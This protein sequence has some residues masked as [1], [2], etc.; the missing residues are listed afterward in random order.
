MAHNTGQFLH[1][2]ERSEAR[3]DGGY[4][5]KWSF[6]VCAA[7]EDED[8]DYSSGMTTQKTDKQAST[9]S[10]G[11]K[12][13]SLRHFTTADP[14][15]TYEKRSSNLVRHTRL[16]L[17]PPSATASNYLTISPAPT[18]GLVLQGR[19]FQHAQMTSAFRKPVQRNDSSSG[20]DAQQGAEVDNIMLTCCG[21]PDDDG[22][23]IKRLVH[24]KRKAAETAAVYQTVCAK[25]S[26]PCEDG[27]ECHHCGN[28]PA[29]LS[30]PSP[31]APLRSQPC[32][33]QSFY[34]ASPAAGG[35]GRPPRA[36][37]LP[38][39]LAGINGRSPPL[40]SA[41]CC[42]GA[43]KSPRGRRKTA[44][45]QHHL[46]HP[47]VLSSDDDAAAADDDD[48][49]AGS[50]SR[51]DSVSPQ[52]ADSAHSSPAPCGGRVEAAVKSS[53]EREE[54]GTDFFDDVNMKMFIPRRT[55]MKDQFGKQLRS[56]RSKRSK[57]ESGKCGSIILQCRS[58][59][60]GT[61]RRMVTKPVVFSVEHIQ[62]ETEGPELNMVEKV[63]LRASELIS[64][65]WCSVR[66]LPVLFFQT[67]PD[68]CVRLRS[69]LDMTQEDCGQWYDCT[70]QESDE[71]YIVLIFMDG[72]DMKEQMILED[73]LSEIGQN[74]NISNFPA[75]LPFDEANTRLVNF[76]KATKQKQDKLKGVPVASRCSPLSRTFNAPTVFE[77]DR[78]DAADLQPAFVGPV[79]K[80]MVYPPPPAKGGILVTNEDLHCLNDGEF[81]NDV[82]IDFYLKYL[83][84]E[85]L[86]KEDSQRIHVFSSFFY[87]RLTQ[88]EKGSAPD[89]SNNLPIHKRK[90]NRVKT[91]TRHVDLFDKDFIFVPINESAHWYLAVICLPGGD[92]PSD[93]L[94]DHCRPLSP[95]MDVL[96]APPRDP[97]PPGDTPPRDPASEQR[98]PARDSAAKGRP[99]LHY[100]NELQRISM[101]YADDDNTLTS[102]EQ[103]SN[104]VLIFVVSSALHLTR[105]AGGARATPRKHCDRAGRVQR[106]QRAGRGLPGLGL[107]RV[108]TG[109]ESRPPQTVLYPHHGLSARSRQVHGGQNSE[110]VPGGG[111]GGAQRQPAHVWEKPDERLQSSCASAGQLQRLRHLRP[112]V[113]GE[114]LRESHHKLSAAPQPVRV[115]P[116]A[117]DEEQTAGNQELDP[118]HP[119]E[120]GRP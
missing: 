88:R 24:H 60:V 113:R 46:D 37:D 94:P 49:G 85:K 101:C 18:Q 57:A 120:T 95:D 104:Q 98:T 96:D 21:V 29:C 69:Q 55:R 58:V 39:G 34:K 31:R 105:G 108:L 3:P 13:P 63:S 75:K 28:R 4:K 27:I 119:S 59:R 86:K 71:K 50:V 87:R 110:R 11:N 62:L 66:K 26:K 67:T 100:P 109:L 1:A 32:S 53:G 25:C 14:L 84:L 112:A 20:G 19:L 38:A 33:L 12:A 92:P 36:D 72:L 5:H 64:C 81:L 82:I 102:D 52:P 41:S 106:R 116:S 35:N 44:A 77:H 54:L 70:G 30:P 7:Q 117:E 97:A 51:L 16:S 103:S 76:N 83:V 93:E 80:L 6:P 114:L 89:R 91:W 74:N 17:A 65:E 99:E 115:V 48:D 111:V 73:I 10:D 47:I 42:Y 9:S 45:Q 90:H 56:P 22:S 118:A 79:V 40:A 107:R 68:E 61:L 78:R 8:E 23:N 2:L 43:R 15:R